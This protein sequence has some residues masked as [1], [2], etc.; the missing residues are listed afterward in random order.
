M[1]KYR[2]GKVLGQGSFGRAILVTNIHNGKQYVMKEID[3]S[4]MPRSEKEA[5]MLEVRLLQS[6]RHPNVV[7]CT[8]SFLSA[9]KLCIVMEWC[10]EGDLYAILKKRRGALLPEETILDW[11]VQICLAIKHV[12]DRK[13]LHRDLKTQNIFVSTG[14]LLK[15]GDFGVSKVLSGTNVFTKTSVGTPYYLSPEI[16]KNQQYNH[17]S[18]IWSLGCVLYE[19]TTLK[20]AFDA[21]S[22]QMLVHKI[23]QGKYPAPPSKYSKPLRDLIGSMIQTDPRKRPAINEI[24]QRPI[25][26]ERIGNFLSQ[27]FIAD[28]FSHTVIHAKPAPGEIVPRAPAARRSPC[29]SPK[30]P[31][32][33]SQSRPS[34][35]VPSRAPSPTPSAGGRSRTPP[36]Q[37]AASG[38]VSAPS[39]V[40]AAAGGR[41][42]VPVVGSRATPDPARAAASTAMSAAARARQQKQEQELKRLAEEK[43][44]RER[45]L[46]EAQARIEEERKRI[47][48]ARQAREA[49]QAA[50]QQRERER[51]AAI[52]ADRQRRAEEEA[53]ARARREA[54]AL[55]ARRRAEEERAQEEA[56]S[57]IKR[58]RESE[59]MRLEAERRK[60]EY[61]MQQYA[62]D[63]QAR[64][65]AEKRRLQ[66]EEARR[67]RA[68]EEE[69]RRAVIEER[70][71]KAHEVEEARKAEVE[72][73]KA[74]EK[75][76]R[77][78]QRAQM[79]AAKKDW[80]ER[81]KE[82]ARNRAR[83]KQQEEGVE[84]M[85]PRRS[86][87]RRPRPEW[88]GPL[89]DPAAAERPPSPPSGAGPLAG[90]ARQAMEQ[91][92]P[93]QRQRW[94]QPADPSVLPVSG[95]SAMAVGPTP[96][97]AMTPEDR[98]RIY[99]EQQE[100]ALRNKQRHREAERQAAEMWGIGGAAG[101]G[102]GA[103]AGGDDTSSARAHAAISDEERRRLFMEQREA[104]RRN[105]E[106]AKEQDRY[107]GAAGPRRSSHSPQPG[108]SPPRRSSRTDPDGDGLT[109]MERKQRRIEEENRRRE[110]ELLEFQRRHHREMRAQA[111]KNRQQ[112]M[113]DIGPAGNG[114]GDV[115]VPIGGEPTLAVPGG[116]K[117][118][119][120]TGQTFTMSRGGQAFQIDLNP[121]SNAPPPA[122]DA[123]GEDSSAEITDYDTGE[124]AAMVRAMHE[125]YND[126]RPSEYHDE[127][128]AESGWEDKRP[129]QQDPSLTP[130]ADGYGYGEGPGGEEE[131][132]AAR[133]EA[134]RMFLEE[135][136]GFDRFLRAYRRMEN[137]APDEDEMKALED[138]KSVLGE[139]NLC[140]LR[141]IH[142]L[143]SCEAALN[144]HGE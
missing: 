126:E 133:V 97:A 128:G 31:A 85:L 29:P 3:V 144:A 27:T 25:I 82:A 76:K 121:S 141:H 111:I 62:Q 118:Q 78:E 38:G 8:E 32:T 107:P 142:Q 89:D 18:D 132:L 70:Q 54:E 77:E 69:R 135:Q 98:R 7:N 43:Q 44:R 41:S 143:I 30:E 23:V 138:L 16:C 94:G 88:Q 139:D 37:S 17:K 73:R 109:P 106:R 115:Q 21:Q 10:Q 5:S 33:P 117:V 136:L 114:A 53:E 19:I 116:G 75:Q 15:L 52:A 124:F 61:E 93:S 64:V 68:V 39:S 72:R 34:S 40:F 51:Q 95:A 83:V 28:E 79:M 67:R 137:M 71:R 112:I 2:K 104:A 36:L 50:A 125:A 86:G 80:E 57:K 1:E 35:R 105:R 90:P 74:E 103:G 24:L 96:G 108:A 140:H 55:E 113:G 42:G 84:V 99:L 26:K 91:R 20:H 92:T 101:A 56:F 110:E 6:L 81:Q 134:L 11:F 131:S 59:L 14:G 120:P 22:L 4:R 49:E 119:A 87:P 46:Q 60:I 127:S 9:G 102:A 58:E 13:I 130:Y 66:Q 47:E 129:S 63:R 100:A 12:H 65:E 48:A 45:E 123:G 122:N